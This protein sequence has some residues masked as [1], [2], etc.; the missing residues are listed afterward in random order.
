MSLFI[1]STDCLIITIFAIYSKISWQKTEIES[2][3]VD[4]TYLHCR[5]F[6]VMIKNLPPPNK[7]LHSNMQEFKIF[8]ADHLKN[9]V[10]KEGQVIQELAES[11][12]DPSEIVTI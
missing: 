7:T 3:K 5:D 12:T 1:V 4:E 11:I 2:R 10:K 8:L 9:V 6:T